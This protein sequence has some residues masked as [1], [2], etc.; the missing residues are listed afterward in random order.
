MNSRKT[1][2]LLS[3]EELRDFIISRMR[4]SHIYQPL[5]IKTLLESGGVAT[6]RQLAS[7]FLAQDESQLLYYEKTLKKMPIKVL[8]KHNILRREGELVTLGVRNLTLEEKAEIKKLCEQ[9]MQEYIASR[10]LSIWDYRLLDD[11]PV[12]DT[13]SLIHI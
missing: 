6:V 10:G 3:F 12:S 5:L 9:R 13:L 4:L 1:G 7:S 11:S 8:T 2:Q